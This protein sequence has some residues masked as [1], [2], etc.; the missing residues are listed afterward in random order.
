MPLTV[1]AKFNL[2]FKDTIDPFTFV[3]SGFYAGVEQWQNDYPSFGL[4]AA[5]YGKRYGAA[6]ADQAVENYMTEAA[7]PSLLH[8]D[9]RYFRK[10]TGSW[11]RRVGYALS[12]TLITRTDDG[13]R[14]VNYSELGG[15]AAAAA[16][17]NLYYPSAD[18]TA[19]E[20]GEKLAVQIASDS[21]F[22]LLLEF[23]PDIRHKFLRG[24]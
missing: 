5:G 18:R 21:G 3:V 1:G 17:S 11:P 12:R 14:T 24:K 22:N 6:Y 4:G 15:S 7:F 13:R 8:Q 20:A 16:I 9:P 23:W 2:A 19:A 10:G